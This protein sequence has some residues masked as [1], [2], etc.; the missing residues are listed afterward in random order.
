MGC[1]MCRA[2]DT[3]PG[4]GYAPPRDMHYEQQ[5]QQL[6][7]SGHGH[8][9][10]MPRQGP[11]AGYVPRRQNSQGSLFPVDDSRH[12][13]TDNSGPGFHP[14]SPSRPSDPYNNDPYAD[15]PVVRQASTTHTRLVRTPRASQPNTPY[16][17]GASD[18]YDE[19]LQSGDDDLVMVCADCYAEICG[20]CAAVCPVTGKM[21]V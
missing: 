13:V 12:V 11:E 1:K 3:R 20:N 6:Y 21:H 14:A 17:G 5:Q 8:A 19:G 18:P 2:V 10:V 4:Y 16:G 9:T 7:G 15:A